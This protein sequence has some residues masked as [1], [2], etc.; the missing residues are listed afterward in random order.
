ME[1]LIVA[2]VL[3]ARPLIGLMELFALQEFIQILDI[4][5]HILLMLIFVP[6]A[7]KVIDSLMID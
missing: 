6:P 7:M 4:V 5:F 1:K 2:F 3:N